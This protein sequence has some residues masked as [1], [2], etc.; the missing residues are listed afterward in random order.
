MKKEEWNPKPKDNKTWWLAS[1]CGPGTLDSKEICGFCGET[2]IK[3]AKKNT[4]SIAD[5]HEETCGGAGFWCMEC[6]RF[7]A[8]DACGE[9]NEIEHRSVDGE[10]LLMKGGYVCCVCGNKLAKELKPL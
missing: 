6:G 10:V 1:H 3:C 9:S 8:Q 5:V 4:E 7:W 2:Y